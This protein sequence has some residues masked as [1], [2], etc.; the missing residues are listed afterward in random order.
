[1][2][3]YMGLTSI[4]AASTCLQGIL[5]ALKTLKEFDKKISTL[6]FKDQLLELREQLL[7]ARD[8]TTTLILENQ[9]LREQLLLKDEMRLQEDGNIL[10]RIENGEQKGPY[11]S[12][13]FGKDKITISLNSSAQQGGW[14]CPVCRNHFNSRQWKADRA[15][16]I[17]ALTRKK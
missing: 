13:C 17:Q 9:D 15:A 1:M 14:H 11:C 7:E 2:D 6:D 3:I 10:W 4:Q 12:A 5:G 8:Q 16:E